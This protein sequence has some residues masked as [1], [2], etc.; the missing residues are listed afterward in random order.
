M[1]SLNALKHKTSP[2]LKTYVISCLIKIKRKVSMQ[3]NSIINSYI[4][5]I[6]D[7]RQIDISSSF[8]HE[9]SDFI[10]KTKKTL[11][12]F[13]RMSQKKAKCTLE[14]RHQRTCDVCFDWA[15]T[16]ESFNSNND[17]INDDK[18]ARTNLFKPNNYIYKMIETMLPKAMVDPNKKHLRLLEM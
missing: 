13:R 6:D 3:L 7:S 15:Q 18:I 8:V 14:L 9:K 4:L 5:A 16:S 10:R 17:K 12:I 1:I 2:T 11:L